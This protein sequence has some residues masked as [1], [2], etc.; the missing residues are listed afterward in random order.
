MNVTSVVI[1]HDMQA[2]FEIA[3]L[4]AFLHEG[5]IHALVTPEE[6]REHASPIIRA[7]LAGRALEPEIGE[8]R[9]A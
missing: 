2:V 1:T 3:D 6:L 4:V 7:F 5:V 9:E 8:N